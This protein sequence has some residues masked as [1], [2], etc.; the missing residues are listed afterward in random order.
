VDWHG[1]RVL[2]VLATSRSLGLS[3]LYIIYFT[4]LIVSLDE[5]A[6]CFN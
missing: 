3:L 2:G 1:Y 6:S 4:E 5:Y